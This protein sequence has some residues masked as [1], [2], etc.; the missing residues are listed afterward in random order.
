VNTTVLSADIP[1][2]IAHAF[3]TIGYR[4]RESLVVVGLSGPR[5]RIGLTVRLDLPVSSR[6]RLPIEGAARMLRNH[7]DDAVVGLV[8]SDRP[9]L[10]ERRA[11]AGAAR[12]PR[13]WLARDVRRRLSAAGFVVRDMLSVTT[14]G[15]RSYLCRDPLC[16]PPHGRSLDEITG[17]AL[18]A[19]HVANGH[20]LAD[21][22]AALL[23]YVD[24]EPGADR[25]EAAPAD[26]RSAPDG[27]A[28]PGGDPGPGEGPAAVSGP[29]GH[30]AP[31]PSGDDADAWSAGS[32]AENLARWRLLL[33]A[34][35]DLRQGAD[36]GWLAGALADR[37]F[38]DAVLVSLLPGSASLSD[39]DVLAVDPA[40]FET[41]HAAPPDRSLLERGSGMLAAVARTA[42]AG[43][44]ADALALLAWAAWWAGEGA[45]GRLLAERALADDAGHTLASLVEQLLFRGVAPSWVR[46]RA[47]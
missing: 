36:V 45:R 1:D 46:R 34:D 47:G 4:P 15:W 38:R 39:A 12:P 2:V 43:C 41:L 6:Q 7:G 24:P 40:T 30:P 9:D 35:G 19:W 27:A 32:A 22:E 23:A 42:P 5:Q 14:S 37:R 3:Y 26:G 10:P 18:A 29:A 21:D 31:G 11:A 28:G 17:S 44:R 25:Q 13:S 33:G 16:C 20:V 8:V